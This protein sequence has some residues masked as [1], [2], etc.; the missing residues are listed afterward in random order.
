[1]R[2]LCDAGSNV[3]L[4]MVPGVSHGFIARD[5]ASRAVAWMSDRFADA[6]V[7]EQSQ[8][9]MMKLGEL[10]RS[11]FTGATLASVRSQGLGNQAGAG[12]SFIGVG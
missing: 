2:Q 5:S 1:M 8:A 3:Q 4:V 12:R 10:S 6:R 9:A 7:P 11:A